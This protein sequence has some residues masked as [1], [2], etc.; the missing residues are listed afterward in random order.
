MG[1]VI[2]S[3][4][5]KVG[6]LVGMGGGQDPYYVNKTSAADDYTDFAK[7]FNTNYRDA[8]LNSASQVAN[9]G[10]AKNLYGAGGLNDRLSDEEQKLA[11]QGFSLTPE[12]RSS[13]GQTSGDIAR[14][15]G[16][17]EQDVSKSLAKRGL[18]SA[19]S[20]AA[21]A[22]YS[23]L[24]GNKNEMLAKAQTDIAQKRYQD[25]MSRLQSVRNQMQSLGVA[26][27]Q[28][29]NAMTGQRLGSQDDILKSSA[30]MERMTNQEGR[31]QMED[32]QAAEKPGLWG[33]VTQGLQ[34]GIGQV[35]S[36]APGM[37]LGGLFG[38]GSY[39]S[40]LPSDRSGGTTS[41]SRDYLS[42]K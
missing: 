10:F 23:G 42:M 40:G 12:D 13:Y 29:T 4:V 31:Q 38:G 28:L 41:L 35:A 15:F 19:G 1:K 33:T 5:N 7:N 16:Q 25:T 6:S 18:A 37:A 3:A 20:G 34:S 39:A 32:Q 8:F 24:A 14:Q 21:G 17:Q 30:N 27:Q 11:S 26:G 9:Q 36:K 22:A 2:G